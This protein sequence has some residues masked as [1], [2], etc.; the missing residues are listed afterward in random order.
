MYRKK[1]DLHGTLAKR[2]LQPS[3]SNP[4]SEGI[5]GRVDDRAVPP[6]ILVKDRFFEPS[7]SSRSS[8]SSSSFSKKKPLSWK[9]AASA[10]DRRPESCSSQKDR[11]PDRS[12]GWSSSHFREP[13]SES[14]TSARWSRSR[15]NRATTLWKG[16]RMRWTTRRARSGGYRTSTRFPLPST[17]NPEAQSSRNSR[18]RS[19]SSTSSWNR[20]F[21]FGGPEFGPSPEEEEASPCSCS[22]PSS[23][24]SSGGGTYPYAYRFGSQLTQYPPQWVFV[25]TYR[26]RPGSFL[27][28]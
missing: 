9:K 14:A 6:F 19:G 8:S 16:S 26:P 24:S 23:S 21:R 4:I 25:N 27:W 7:S 22:P 5:P 10:S 20:G 12:S 13:G 15:W 1:S 17:A 2:S 11:N 3:R 18:D 28:W